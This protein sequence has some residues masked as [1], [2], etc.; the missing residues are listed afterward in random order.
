MSTV[1]ITSTAD[2]W[3]SLDNLFGTERV[4]RLLGV[5]PGSV[6]RYRSGARPTPDKLAARLHFL[7]TVIGDLAGAYNEFGIRRWFERARTALGGRSPAELMQ[8]DWD[9]E[10]PQLQRARELARSLT[11]SPAT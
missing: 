8:G 6:R 7:A 11:A 1:Q 4:S 3:H 5:S 9:P 10:D 2:E